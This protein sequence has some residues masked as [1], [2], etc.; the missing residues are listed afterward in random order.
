MDKGFR[1]KESDLNDLTLALSELEKHI[2]KLKK[3]KKLKLAAKSS[4]DVELIWGG[5]LHNEYRTSLLSA[6][7]WKNKCYDIYKNFQLY[8]IIFTPKKMFKQESK[9]WAGKV[10]VDS[11]PGCC[12]VAVL[13]NLE[14]DEKI[15]DMGIGEHLLNIT[16]ALCR[17]MKYSMLLATTH[18]NNLKINHIL[19]KGGWIGPAYFVN[20]R[21]TNRILIRIK[22]INFDDFSLTDGYTGR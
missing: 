10:T 20:Q 5:L 12:G 11:L 8:L 22:K 3:D 21:T 2:T 16:E 18:K 6:D 14:L 15:R 19:D 17:C 9:W 1:P 13:N 4:I 7:S